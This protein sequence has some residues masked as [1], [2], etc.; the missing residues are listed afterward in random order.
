MSGTRASSQEQGSVRSLV[1]V[2]RVLRRCAEV[3]LVGVE[4]LLAVDGVTRQL[5][6]RL[7]AF[8]VER[9]LAHEP[10]RLRTAKSHPRNCCRFVVSSVQQFDPEII[11]AVWLSRALCGLQ[12]RPGFNVWVE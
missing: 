5:L 2:K 7:R 8:G 1:R 3:K 10:H 4:G 11:V 9:L 12:E 6:Q